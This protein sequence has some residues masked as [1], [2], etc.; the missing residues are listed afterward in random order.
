MIEKKINGMP[1]YIYWDS[2]GIMR[3]MLVDNSNM[4]VDVS[5]KWVVGRIRMAADSILMCAGLNTF[6]EVMFLCD[7]RNRLH[8]KKSAVV[9]GQ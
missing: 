3:T 5:K 4:K 7:M 9:F 1:H 2:N 6:Q 8:Q